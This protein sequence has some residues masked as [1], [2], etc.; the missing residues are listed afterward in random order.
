MLKHPLRRLSLCLA[1]AVAPV[2]WAD[3]VDGITVDEAR[4]HWNQAL[5]H[6]E[7]GRAGAAVIAYRQ[8]QGYI[9]GGVNPVELEAARRAAPLAKQLA[10][11]LEQQDRLIAGMRES[12]DNWGAFE[13]YEAGAHFAEADRVL[14]VA[15]TKQPEDLALFDRARQHFGNRSLPSFS[16][17]NRTRLQAVAGY[18]LD[19]SLLE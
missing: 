16:A 5:A 2:A 19:R 11:A 1:L 4:D 7:G 9:C 8:A 3:C 13:W 12:A 17:N 14:F 10:A 6:E 18:S 15:L